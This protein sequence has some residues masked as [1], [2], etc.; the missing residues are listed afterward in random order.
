[1]R[2]KSTLAFVLT[3]AFS[4][5]ATAKPNKPTGLR[6]AYRK[7]LADD[8]P[9]A[10][11]E[12]LAPE[13]QAKIDR[14]EFEARWKANAAERKRALA[15]LDGL[16]RDLEKPVRAGTTTHEGGHTLE[17]A[18]VDGEYVIV[19]G[20]PGVPSTI[21]P[22]STI[23]A[24]LAALRRLDGT[25]LDRLLTP[26]LQARVGEDWGGRADKIEA[27]LDTPGRLKYSEPDH[28]RA[29][30]RYDAGRM[31]V[32]ERTPRGWRIADFR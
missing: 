26:E 5:C 7:A 12:L 23:R 1:M 28:D 11:Y 20:L 30:L 29:T 2:N 17:W 6:D 10:A 21:T 13:V 31:L 25:D 3:L 15:E 27:A 8:D 32:L 24:L 16:P 19:A 22:E 9:A 18:L 14:A 4:A